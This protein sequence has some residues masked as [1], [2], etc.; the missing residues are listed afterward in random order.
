MVIMGATHST[1]TATTLLERMRQT[2]MLRGGR[3]SERQLH[4]K[5]KVTA[6]IAS[7]SVLPR[8]A[9]RVAFQLVLK[10][11]EAELGNQVVWRGLGDQLKREADHLENEMGLVPRQIVVG[12]P[13]LSAAEIERLLSELVAEEATIARTV[14]N[15]ALDA[16]DPPSAARRYLAEYR[17]VVEQ[18]GTIDSDIARTLANATFMA[19]VPREKARHHFKHFA[20]LATRFRDNIGF[21]RT[22]ARMAFRAPDPVKAAKRFVALHDTVEAVLTSDGI[23]PEI[24]RTLAGIASLTAQPMPTA[25]TLLKNFEN[26]VNVV[27]RTHPSVARSI[28]LSACRAADPL[29]MGRLYAKNYDLIVRTISELDPHRARE[30]AG[31][32][33]RS[34]NPLRWAKRY[35]SELQQTRS[36]AR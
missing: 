27:S 26:V 10:F 9:T 30:V 7:Q 23:E 31:Q 2:P 25:R 20:E 36:N 35:L 1:M 8:L 22:V 32:A 14:L 16:A 12:L 28:A 24:A 15:A 17:R 11:D 5:D 33:F 13:K 4:L 19:R 21:A 6:A 34:D 29:K 3:I 18:F